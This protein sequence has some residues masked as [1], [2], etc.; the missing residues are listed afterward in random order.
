MMGV[1][2]PLLAAKPTCRPG[3]QELKVVTDSNR[4][5]DAALV[6]V[7]AVTV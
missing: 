5:G 3:E 1:R 4:G 2:E 7:M 6:S